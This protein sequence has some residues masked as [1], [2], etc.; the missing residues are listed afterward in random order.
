MRARSLLR[1]TI[2]WY[3]YHWPR[4]NVKINWEDKRYFQAE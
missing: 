1:G 3:F 2:T 4:V